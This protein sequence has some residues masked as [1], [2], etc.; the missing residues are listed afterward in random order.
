MNMDVEDDAQHRKIV[1]ARVAY[2]R[3]VFEA[4]LVRAR[5]ERKGEGGRVEGGGGRE[6]RGEELGVQGAGVAVRCRRSVPP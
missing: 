6:E 3:E 2:F 4:S 1:F 5:G